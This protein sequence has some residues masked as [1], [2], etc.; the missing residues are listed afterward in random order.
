MIWIRKGNH[1]PASHSSPALYLKLTFILHLSSFLS[2]GTFMVSGPLVQPILAF[3]GEDVLLSCHLFPK[4]DAR[5]M[6]VKWVSGPLV[7]VLYRRGQEVEDVQAPLFQ[8]R[9][10]LLR[11]DM[12]EGK[13]TVII[14]QVQLSD[15]GQ[16]T[17]YFQAGTFHNETSFDLQVTENLATS[18]KIPATMILV[19][20]LRV[21]I[22]LP[23]DQLHW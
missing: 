6:T 10:K 3:V 18:Q 21:F 7:V 15:S 11:Q 5:G 9:T 20:I 23:L 19:I 1:W 12:A 14:H 16:Y 2:S 4:M 13:V 22:G 8:G 17:C